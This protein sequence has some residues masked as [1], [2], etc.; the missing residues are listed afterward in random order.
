MTE[1]RTWLIDDLLRSG[2]PE[3]LSLGTARVAPKPSQRLLTA[4]G[5]DGPGW[6][7]RA[8][9]ILGQQVRFRRTRLPPLDP[10]AGLPA[11]PRPP[12]SAAARPLML[13]LFAGR[14]EAD[15]A[16]VAVRAALRRSGWRVH[17]FDLPRLQALFAGASALGPA[18]AAFLRRVGAAAATPEAEGEDPTELAELDPAA[19]RAQ[20]LPVQVQVLALLR[21]RDRTLGRERL[22]Q[23]L[24]GQVAASRARL[25]EA[26][27][28][29]LA[30]DDRPLLEA[31]AADRAQAVRQAATALLARLPGTAVHDERIAAIVGRVRR[32]RVGVVGRR[33]ALSVEVPATLSRPI[34]RARFALQQI[35]G[36]SLRALAE[37]LEL[38]L[39]ALLDGAAE[40][41]ALATALLGLALA[42]GETDAV[43]LARQMPQAQ[44]EALL[45]ERPHELLRDAATGMAVVGELLR[46]AEW[47][48]LPPLLSA[49]REASEEP[50][51]VAAAS[52]L[53]DCVAWRRH[54]AALAAG[55]E[56]ARRHLLALVVGLLP[57]T[58]RARAREQLQ[59]VPSADRDRALSLLDLLDLLDVPD[60]PGP[61]PTTTAG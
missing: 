48:E 7:L 29:S 61:P 45:L 27:L 19:L 8:L 23:L 12:V 54:L 58:L 31:L 51:P 39:P 57:A 13:R 38:A 41:G 5:G 18:D 25:I 35:A 28:S 30:D 55:E 10:A 3:A 46:P 53:L 16:A 36:V 37:R 56:P 14:A 20:S 34:D 50:L 26:L 47:T 40:D 15:G 2:L 4:L 43:A 60:R 21:R 24:P 44:W 52:E 6:Q 42:D 11:D 33:T 49:L 32:S 9:A 17:P 59:G 1:A 22:E